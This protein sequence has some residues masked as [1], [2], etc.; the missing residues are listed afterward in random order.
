MQPYDLI[1]SSQRI[2]I[3]IGSA[4]ITDEKTGLVK[5]DW[6]DSLTNDIQAL[7]NQ[8]KEITIVSSGAIALGRKGVGISSQSRPSS[9]PLKLKQAAAALGQVEISRA[10][11]DSFA[12]H[13]LKTALVL[14]TPKDTEARRS[15]LNARAT[16]LTLLRNKAVPIINENDTVSTTEIRFGDNDRLASRVAQMIEADLVVQ[17]S[18]TDGL[19]TAD[20]TQ[21]ETAKHI[22]LVEEIND[23]LFN[24]AGDAPAGLSTG[25][26]KSKLKAAQI[27]T[28]A[29]VHMMVTSGKINAPLSNIERATIFKASTKPISARKK[30]I[31]SHVKSEGTMIIDMGAVKAL[32]SGN[33]LLPAGAVKIEGDFKHGDP[34]DI[35]DKEGNKLA[36]GLINYSADEARLILGVKSADISDILGFT[37][38]NVLV[39]RDNLALIA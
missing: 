1:Q 11:A 27:A 20:P 36:L 16:L 35:L 15:H 18:T 25:G 5:Q 30:W 17:L 8:G 26:M 31:S 38:G 24:M 37:R 14:L 12:K 3:K 29:G 13:N 2:V 10:Y 21:D 32:Q 4:I 33:S 22:P 19:Y 9:I 28:Q 39:H 23:S 34:V 6:L 7:I